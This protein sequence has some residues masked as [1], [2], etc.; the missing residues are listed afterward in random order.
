M[1]KRLAA[2]LALLLVAF[3]GPRPAEPARP[4]LASGDFVP[5][6]LLVRFK[7]GRGP[8]ALNELR[9]GIQGT[10]ELPRLGVHRLRVPPGHEQDL[11]ERLRRR[12]DVEYAQPNYV[13]R[14]LFTP[15]DRYFPD[16]WNLPAIHAP[17]A[18]DVT[19]GTSAIKVAVVDTGVDCGHLDLQGQCTV[20]VNYV[21]YDPG[22]IQDDNG[23]GTRVAGIIAARTNND[24]GIAG[25]AAGVRLVAL[26]ALDSSGSGDTV[27]VATAILEAVSIHGARVIN[28]SLGGPE[29]DPTLQ[30]AI[31]QA[32][33]AGAVIVAAAGNSGNSN[34]VYPA[35]YD[36]VIAVAAVD[37]YLQRAGFSNHGSYIDLA[38][39][40]VN[41]LSTV[42]E[43]Q[44]DSASGTSMAAPH[45]SAVAALILSL[46][47][48]LGPDAVASILFRT[49]E[50]LGSSGWDPYY[51]CG[52][53]NAYRAV[54][55]V[56]AA[57][58]PV[59]P[60]F[61][62]ATRASAYPPPSIPSF[63]FRL[64]LPLIAVG[65]LC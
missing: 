43:S 50:D 48:D 37:R 22:P 61:S 1:L 26:K 10:E 46:R 58:E 45:V 20:Q 30:N 9:P 42:P 49:A 17:E 19:Q 65:R 57:A 18:W 38:A 35:A 15:N 7:P 14:A 24:I 29:N 16:Q 55:T 23:H 52:L 59:P 5:G 40:G 63:H 21:N 56:A 62:P 3:A 31:N 51:G 53:V 2:F 25:I 32:Y 4:G 13:Y 28:L 33:N 12:P 47:P 8:A 60:A 54:R 34:P 39:P 64:Y 6:E 44:Y 36:H 11:I 27:T 41:I